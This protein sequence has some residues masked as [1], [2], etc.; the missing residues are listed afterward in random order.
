MKGPSGRTLTAPYQPADRAG[1]TFIFKVTTAINTA[2]RLGTLLTVPTIPIE[3]YNL[4]SGP[5]AFRP[6]NHV[7]IQVPQAAANPVYV[8]P[9]NNTAPVVGGPGIE[10]AA[11]GLLK[12]ELAGETFLRPKS[13]GDHPVNTLTAIQVIATAATVLLVTFFD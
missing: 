5:T 11:G 12:L 3:E 2:Q 8:S 1:N 10:I 13:A 6:P 7:W 9:D 4:S